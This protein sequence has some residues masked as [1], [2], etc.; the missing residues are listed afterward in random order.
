MTINIIS[1][2]PIERQPR[3]L[4]AACLVLGL[5]FFLSGCDINLQA[6]I[7]SPGLD[8]IEIAK[9]ETVS[10][11]GSAIGGV[12]DSTTTTDAD[13]GSTTTATTYGYYWDTDGNALDADS[14]ASTATEAIQVT[15]DKEGTFRV[16]LTVTDSKGNTDTADVRVRVGLSPDPLQAI[17]LSPTLS[18][19]KV[20]N[21]QPVIFKGAGIGGNAFSD[22]DPYG[23]YWNIPG[24][25]GATATESTTSSVSSEEVQVTFITNGVY[26]IT[27]TVKDSQGVI[28][29]DSFQL[30]VI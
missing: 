2:R 18:A 23:Y 1:K 8:Q 7:L 28:A 19:I 27:F 30:T 22:D 10:F 14:T 9:G 21:G 6:I 29:T 26:T 16:S 25:P 24:I 20:V 4:L 3:R 17:I 15:F 11:Q 5:A 12:T 13:G